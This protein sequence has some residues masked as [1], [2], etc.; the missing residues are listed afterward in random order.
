MYDQ[1]YN[2]TLP[3]IKADKVRDQRADRGSNIVFGTD[4][5]NTYL[6]ENHDQFFYINK[7]FLIENRFHQLPYAK[8]DM[9]SKLIN[10][11]KAHHNV[12]GT[13]KDEWITET[14]NTYFDK[15][16]IKIDNALD[17]ALKQ[18]L[19]KNHFQ[20]G[21]QKHGYESSNQEI[22][23]KQGQPNKLNAELEKDLRQHHFAEHDG[24]FDWRTIYR[25]QYIWKQPTD[26]A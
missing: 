9:N 25:E 20:Y 21:F 4:K 22:G 19:R 23:S 3:A 16:K 6:T 17:S 1:G 7:I 13:D 8:R 10:D 24:D 26:E 2:R 12:L 14:H 18:D 15:T 11:L 5:S